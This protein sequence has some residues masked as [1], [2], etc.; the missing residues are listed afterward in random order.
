MENVR[1]PTGGTGALAVHDGKIAAVGS[2]VDT[3]PGV[4]RIDGRGWLALPAAIDWHVHFRDP[5]APHK[6][7]LWTGSRAAVKGGVATCGDM[8]N[9]S[10]ATTTVRALEEK[11]ARA[12]GCPADL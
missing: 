9:T 8:P 1:L 6:E 10:P 3:A 11:L 12:Q 5:G 7:T 2:R 4:P